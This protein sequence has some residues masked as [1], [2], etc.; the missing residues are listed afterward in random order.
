MK[1]TSELEPMSKNEEKEEE[2]RLK[3]NQKLA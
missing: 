1:K 2:K 3:S